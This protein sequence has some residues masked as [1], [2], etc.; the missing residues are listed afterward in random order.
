MAASIGEREDRL[1]KAETVALW[2]AIS[3]FELMVRQMDS[4]DEITPEEVSTEKQRL[5]LAKRAL[6]KVNK[7]RKQGL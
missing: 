2:H 1:T 3:N 6:R 5:A 4:M 7:L